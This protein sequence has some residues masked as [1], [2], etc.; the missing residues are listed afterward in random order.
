[1][2]V[3]IGGAGRRLGSQMLVEGVGA[4]GSRRLVRRWGVGVF[5][6]AVILRA[7]RRLGC[8]M[9]REGVGVRGRRLVRLVVV[10]DMETTGRKEDYVVVDGIG[11][12][13]RGLESRV[14]AMA[15]G[16]MLGVILT[17][18]AATTFVATGVAT[19]LVVARHCRDFLKWY[20]L[21][22]IWTGETS[23]KFATKMLIF[24]LNGRG[25][26]TNSSFSDRRRRGVEAEG[27]TRT[28]VQFEF[29]I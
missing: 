27:R 5:V 26:G 17:R 1:M 22:I 19:S 28:R 4:H 11:G 24:F 16:M 2:V 9:L 12:D 14:V 6:V 23:K 21:V 13:W 8:Q 3:I 10:A 25:C 15:V 20:V 7:G 18:S 29:P